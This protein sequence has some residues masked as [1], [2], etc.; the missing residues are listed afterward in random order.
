LALVIAV[1]TPEAQ[2]LGFD[3]V[4]LTDDLLVSDPYEGE[5]PWRAWAGGQL[6]AAA[7]QTW[8]EQ[9]YAGVPVSPVNPSPL[10]QLYKALP[11][12]AA[13]DAFV[14]CGLL[15]AG[16][17]AHALAGS[18][19]A[20]SFGALLAGIAY[21]QSGF[22]VARTRHSN[23]FEVAAL[24]PWGLL[25]AERLAGPRR[26][27]MAGPALAFV[28]AWQVR[29][30]FPQSAFYAGLAYAGWIVLRG[31]LGRDALRT[32]AI[33]GAAAVLGTGMGVASLLPLAEI[34]GQSERA[35]TWALTDPLGCTG[36]TTRTSASARS[37]WR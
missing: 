23:I 12:A 20:G 25:A 1:V 14:L 30:G 32:L 33:A 5:L 17:G 21:G 7:G 31:G 22:M 15:I 3:K 19:G 4:M 18:L 9:I 36:R 11:P 10:G 26:S 6:G 27:R 34:A 13:Q 16:F 8:T 24:L 37:C 29:A 35:A 2:L 28:F